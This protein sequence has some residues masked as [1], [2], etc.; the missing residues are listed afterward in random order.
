M[1]RKKIIV[2]Q[3]RSDQGRVSIMSPAEIE[4]QLSELP[5][6]VLTELVRRANKAYW[7]DNCPALSDTLYDRIVSRLRTLNP[8]SEVLNYLGGAPKGVKLLG[9]AS[10][11]DSP[12]KE[13]HGAAVQHV[14][15]MLSLGKCYSLDHL[16][17]WANAQGRPKGSTSRTPLQFLVMP[18]MD[19]VACSLRYDRQGVLYLA[20]T[21]GDGAKGEDVTASVLEISSIPKKVPLDKLGVQ[22]DK[23]LEVRGE[24]YM[25]RSVFGEQ[26]SESYANP[27]NLAASA[28][29]IK[30]TQAISSYGLG[31]F[32]YDILAEGFAD[33]GQKLK[34]LDALGFTFFQSRVLSLEDVLTYI[35]E[36]SKTRPSLDY[37]IDGVVVKLASVE[38]QKAAGCTDHHPR[39]S[40]AY[41]FQ[42]ETGTTIL[43]DVEWGVSRSGRITPVACFEP[44][45]LSG[46]WVS[47]ATLHSLGAFESLNLTRG[48]EVTITR[49]GGVIPH[50]DGVAGH[51]SGLRLS[52]PSDCPACG[53]PAKIEETKTG[54]M[55]MCPSPLKCTLA[56]QAALE[57]FA[58]AMGLHGYGPKLLGKLVSAGLLED[59][60]GFYS[61]TAPDLE[62]IAN[63]GSKRAAE[64]VRQVHETKKAQ[65]EV[66]LVA[67][68][69]QGLGRQKARAL[70]SQ[71]KCLLD[72]TKLTEEDIKRV[73]G[74]SAL[75][76]KK[77]KIEL[78]VKEHI[79]KGLSTIILIEDAH[80]GLIPSSSAS[81]KGKS[82]LFSGGMGQV[83]R[84]RAEDLV[85][86]R[87]GVVK[88]TVSRALDYLVMGHGAQG[89]TKTK[90]VQQMVAQGAEIAI[91]DEVEFIGL[92]EKGLERHS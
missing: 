20:A 27:R 76:A 17:R 4:S 21:R 8:Q 18:K 22:I 48:C 37:E 47:R 2:G 67:L 75:S 9:A 26:F 80:E 57:H 79:I 12:P 81:V 51:S 83:T 36:T 64:L 50:V 14:K 58:K 55:L 44:I 13:R 89:S 84:T 53:A 34:A 71:C 5:A 90:K 11:K 65:L 60:T 77:L 69:I 88:R 92:I 29:R 43:T 54:K 15:R 24:I 72:V 86:E 38:L 73:E 59:P 61:L 45:E 33:E 16:K 1:V 85:R 19:G 82:F 25:R 23:G 10:L 74:F 52:P 78:R 30:K 3:T 7:E 63:V 31:F 70:A 28:L 40:I 46:A 32:S 41:K 62:G 56:K 91:L 87:G 49:R 68:A 35:E 6:S 42:G 66:V 39:S